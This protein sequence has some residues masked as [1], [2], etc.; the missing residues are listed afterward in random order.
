MK[1]FP[2]NLANLGHFPLWLRHLTYGDCPSVANCFD[3][4]ISS[5]TFH[6]KVCIWQ[7]GEKIRHIFGLARYFGLQ[8]NRPLVAGE[9]K[10]EFALL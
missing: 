10:I 4:T 9:R 3:N 5:E 7:A 2:S 1:P 8:M 6:V